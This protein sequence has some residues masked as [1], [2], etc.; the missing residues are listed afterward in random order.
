MLAF[1]A[2][3]GLISPILDDL[4][5]DVRFFNGG[6]TT[7]RSFAE[8]ELGPKDSGGNPL[9]GEIYTVLQRRIHLSRSPAACRARSSSMP[10]V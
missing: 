3:V 9:G 1:G 7:V 6:G 10:A 4:P 2:R 8:R 5:I